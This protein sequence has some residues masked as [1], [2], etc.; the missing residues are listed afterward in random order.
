MDFLYPT[1]DD[2]EFNIKIADKKEFRDLQTNDAIVDPEKESER[3]CNLAFELR[4]HQQFVKNFLS[5]NTPYNS[6]LLYHGLG[7]GKTCSA[8]GVCEEMRTYMKQANISKRIIVVASP[9]VQENFKLQLFDDRKLKQIN[10]L[11]NIEACSGKQFLQ[12]INPTNLK[13]LKKERLLSQVDRIIKN[14]YLFLGYIEFGNYIEKV[15]TVEKEG[16]AKEEREKLQKKKLERAFKNRL[17]VIDE[18]HNIRLSD[19]NKDKRIA[20]NLMKLVEQVD[21]SRLLLMSATPMYN[22]YKEIVWLLNLMN[23]N[24]GHAPIDEATIFDKQGNFV[25]GGNGEPLGRQAL[26]DAARGLVSFIRGDNPYTFPFRIYPYDYERDHSTRS[27]NFVYP[28][29]TINGKTIVQ[30][31]EFLDLFVV[32]IGSY[33]K[34]IYKKIVADMKTNQKK[35]KK[36]MPTAE[37][38]EKFGYTVLQKPLEALNIVY[39]QVKEK[40]EKGKEENTK[41]KSTEYDLETM[42]GKAGLNRIMTHEMNSGRRTNY[43]YKTGFLKKFG[44]IF[45]KD[46]IGQYS[47]KIAHIVDS[48]LKSEGIVLVYSQYLDGGLLPVA[49]ALEES[50]L[51]NFTGDSMLKS[52]SVSKSKETALKYAMITGDKTLSTNNAALVKAAGADDN[53]NGSKIK[54]ILISRAGS[55]GLDFKNIRQVH[56]MEPWYNTN[57]IEQIIGRGVRNCSHKDLPFSKRNVMIFLYGTKLKNDTEAADMYVY[58]VAEEKALKIGNVSRVLKEGAVDCLLHAGQSGLTE[59][60]FEMEKT[61]E[62]SN[63]KRIQYKVGDKK[64]SQLCDFM[65]NCEYT[66]YTGEREKA[67]ADEVDTH[68]YDEHFIRDVSNLKRS[69]KRL[70]ANHYFYKKTDL[71]KILN[72]QHNTSLEQIYFALDAI[73]KNP[74]EFLVDMYGRVGSLANIGNYYFYQPNELKHKGSVI[75]E[76]NKPIDYKRSEIKLIK[77]KKEKQK[78]VDIGFDRTTYNNLL[79]TLQKNYEKTQTTNE[80]KKGDYDWFKHSAN[81]LEILELFGVDEKAFSLFVVTHIVDMLLLPEK[82]LLLNYFYYHSRDEELSD[83]EKLLKKI[84]DSKLLRE[85]ALF[86][87]NKGVTNLYI[88]GETM[89]KEA[90]KTDYVELKDVLQ[91]KIATTIPKL[92]TIL[93]FVIEF[94]K[95]YFVFKTKNLKLK[96]HRGAR[97][98]QARKNDT[99]KTLVEITK[100]V[101]LKNND[102]ESDK[103]EIFES[104]NN[105]EICAFME[106]LLRY[107]QQENM[108]N[109]VWFIEPEYSQLLKIEEYSL[110]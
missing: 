51:M 83:F 27:E 9:N 13:N 55:E 66:C 40:E 71:L 77:P 42:V 81:I 25:L 17:I 26:T 35:S 85:K 37:N 89:W 87:Q 49:L 72:S 11:W 28:K 21:G 16:I 29:K 22:S 24:N 59:E 44:K 32:D 6:L 73:M 65:E 30:T 5:I 94:K 64:F 47:A 8:I 57:R 54:V 109:K 82:L 98:D 58:R 99:I 93:G 23:L 67:L 14:N 61:L 106:F 33:Q 50:G 107:Y 39:P 53:M 48:V 20:V 74:N 15:M 91:K 108:E 18:V 80:V 60:K 2:P 63:K 100:N 46:L 92:N 90:E 105:I 62:L 56:I 101:E 34:K 79:S 75:S 110:K 95:S 96:R 4:P 45:T 3:L 52:P 78:D 70:F 103:N 69:I 38:M 76:K 84:L 41:E 19:D 31:I 86:I 102:E 88:R 43:N 104:M 36:E 1:Y 68:T 7:T 12:E 97:C 10:G